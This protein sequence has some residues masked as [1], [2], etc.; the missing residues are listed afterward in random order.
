MFTG[1]I[2][3]VGTVGRLARSGGAGARASIGCSLA[4][5]VLGESIAVNGV[6]LTVDR[7]VSGGFEADLSGETLERSTLGSLVA[8]TKVN[9]ERATQLGARMGGHIV[10]GHVDGVGAI[11]QLESVG[12]A[13]R[14]VLAGPAE[15]AHL[16]AHKGSI[17]IDGVSLTVNDVS[18]V[19]D[20]VRFSVM[21]VPHTLA[22]TTLLELPAGAR[23]NLEVDVLARYI[24]RQLTAARAQPAAPRDESTLLEK[25]RS[26]GY[27]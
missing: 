22:N 7:I 24:D 23:V 13:R 11:V 5:L 16:I 4:P 12:V 18:D 20:G 3:E 10:Q 8:G 21:L 19:A 2:E 25:L 27:M 6:C 26:G 9:L 14:A 1:L 17:S 15:I